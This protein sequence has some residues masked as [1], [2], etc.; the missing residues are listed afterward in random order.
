M[1]LQRE[2]TNFYRLHLLNL[3]FYSE[4]FHAFLIISLTKSIII[5]YS[6][7]VNMTCNIMHILYFSTIMHIMT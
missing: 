1:W 6:D 7:Y 3:I 5:E 2:I 4:V